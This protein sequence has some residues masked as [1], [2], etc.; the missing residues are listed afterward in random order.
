MSKSNWHLPLL[1]F[2]VLALLIFV[3]QNIGD[4]P[5]YLDDFSSIVNSP[6]IQPPVDFAILW[7]SNK[8]RFIPYSVFALQYELFSGQAEGFH[9]VSLCLHLL[10]SLILGLLTVKLLS[11]S[12]LRERGGEQKLASGAVFAFLVASVIFAIVSQNTQIVVYIVQQAGLWAALFYVSALVCYF[13]LR[14]AQS[15]NGTL[16]WALLFALS[17]FCGMLS[18][19]NFATL[20]IAI[21]LIEW[22]FFGKYLKLYIYLAIGLL[23]SA[24]GVLFHLSS[25]STE[26]LW[27]L[28]DSLTRETHLIGRVDY[29][30]TQL[31][32]LTHYIAQFFYPLSPFDLRLE[33]DW[34]L[35]KEWAIVEYL[36]LAF[37]ASLILLAFIYRKKLPLF[38]FGILL[39][40]VGHTVESSFIPITDI[41][42]EH[43]TYLPNL[44][45]AIALTSL[46]HRLFL[47]SSALAFAILIVFS[48]FY[49]YVSLERVNTWTDKIS[50]Y[51]N[52]IRVSPDSARAYSVV[53]QNLAQSGQC[54]L[55]LGYFEHIVSLYKLQD[56]GALGL[57]AE[58]VLSY[59]ECLRELSLVRDADFYEQQLLEQVKSPVKQSVILYKKG[60][61]YV[62]HKNFVA[63][64]EPLTLALKLNPKNYQVVMSLVFTKINLN[65]EHHARGLLKHA[66][67]IKPR[68]PIA[69][70]WLKKLDQGN[71]SSMNTSKGNK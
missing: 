17:A 52:E 60:S 53:A 5:F 61:Y 71:K 62:K 42:F 27:V 24:T 8:A 28:V 9:Y 23:V 40:Y 41:V 20:P 56:E 39:F 11:Y 19:Q 63:A 3:Y 7:E 6:V 54:P 46:L 48:C 18:K 55:A 32:V 69:T 2:V 10:V 51:E 22:L 34:H 16:F 4:I 47:R 14:S 58:T 30:T 26:Q 15:K 12:D 38:S 33:Y 45:L 57:Q 65:K 1:S 35:V 36:L 67:M 59:I 50:F 29:F 66:L 70:K 31:H 49:T 68:D 43:R 13:Q 25:Y 37:H 64:E 44:G 21:L